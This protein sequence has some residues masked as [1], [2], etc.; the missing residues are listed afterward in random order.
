M[1][2]DENRDDVDVCDALGECKKH[3][4]KQIASGASFFASPRRFYGLEENEEDLPKWHKL[5][6]KDK[7]YEIIN[8]A[9]PVA[10]KAR[11]E[12][13]GY[14]GKTAGNVCIYACNQPIKA[15]CIN[16]AG[17][18]LEASNWEVLDASGNVL[19]DSLDDGSEIEIESLPTHSGR[20]ILRACPDGAKR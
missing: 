8:R 7:W 20:L 5:L 13:S 9:Q 2:Q 15:S 19:L 18:S 4:L 6:D 3:I 11:I 12:L 14:A 10:L 16:S 17:D 1:W